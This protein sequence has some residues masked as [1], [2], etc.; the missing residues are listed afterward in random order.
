MT[1]PAPKLPGKLKI[2]LGYA[3]GVG[4]TYQMLEEAQA[5]RASG[6]DVV[7]GYFE[8][9]GRKD[10]IAKTGGLPMIPR[11]TVEYRGTIF[12]EMDADAIIARHPQVAVVDEFPHTNVPG[13][14]RE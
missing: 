1:D 5:L 8:S 3:A 7:I 6:V 14:G 10:T 4:K 12:E 2:F 9:H 11:K 13:S